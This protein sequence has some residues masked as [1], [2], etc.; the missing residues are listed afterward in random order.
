MVDDV[1]KITKKWLNV[2]YLSQHSYYERHNT[3]FYHIVTPIDKETR[4]ISLNVV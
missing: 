4:R 1:H 3:E 2:T